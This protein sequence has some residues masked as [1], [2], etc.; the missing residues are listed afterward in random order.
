MNYILAIF[1]S[2]NETLYFANMFKTSGFYAGI[3]NTPK[4]AGQVCGISVKFH[5]RSL[6]LAR[7][8][9]QNK[10]FRSF[11]GFYKVI[12]VGMRYKLEKIS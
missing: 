7:Q 4:E 10:P 2:R 11:V 8:F 1:S 12:Q 6:V 9:L 5:D 3:V